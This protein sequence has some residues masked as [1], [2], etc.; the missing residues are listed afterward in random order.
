LE[1]IPGGN[2][3]LAFCHDRSKMMFVFRYVK[4]FNPHSA[5]PKCNFSRPSGRAELW[6]CHWRR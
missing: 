1:A 5:L 4:P 3:R 2:S 6:I